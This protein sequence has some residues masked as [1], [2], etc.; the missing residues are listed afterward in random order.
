MAHQI[1]FWAKSCSGSFVR[2]VSLDFRMRSSQRA[3]AD[4]A[5]R[6]R[7]VAPGSCWWRTKVSDLERERAERAAPPGP[8]EPI[9]TVDDWIG[10][11]LTYIAGRRTKAQTCQ[12]LPI[13]SAGTPRGLA[14]MAS[15]LGAEW[16]GGARRSRR[17]PR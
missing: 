16:R 5:A 12:L 10:Y 4:A 14:E 2:Q 8:G 17:R 3:G 9:G 1:W 7:P 13:T 15:R 6:G 11:W